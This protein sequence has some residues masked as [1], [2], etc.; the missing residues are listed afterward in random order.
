MPVETVTVHF[1]F[2][3]PFA[4]RGAEVV[5]R[6]AEPLGVRFEWNHFSLYQANYRG[7]DGWQLWNETIEPDDEHGTMGL[8]PF[9]ASCAARRQGDEAHDRFRLRLLRARYCQQRAYDRDTV[10]AVASEADLHLPRFES[11]LDDPEC[12]TQ[13]ARDHHRARA[14]HVFGTPTF[15]FPDGHCAYFRLRELPGDQ[16]EAL[17]LF[18]A[19]HD[20]LVRFPYLQTIKRP[21]ARGN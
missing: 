2:L 9:L 5:Q 3:C 10:L 21:R 16:E 18:R 4:W 17:A 14:E 8:L 20:T 7:A 12:R 15:Q 19:F 1:D 6:V 13:L 11:D